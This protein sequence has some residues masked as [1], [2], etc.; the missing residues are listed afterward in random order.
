MVALC[1]AVVAKQ[2]ANRAKAI[3]VDQTRIRKRLF[4]ILIAASE[5]HA[6][7]AATKIHI[8]ACCVIPLHASV[9][10]TCRNY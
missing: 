9:P 6:V 10:S 4:L 5:W 1:Y 8:G 3:V 7:R 2:A